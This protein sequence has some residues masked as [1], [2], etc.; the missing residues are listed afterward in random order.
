MEATEQARDGREVYRV[1][2]LCERRVGVGGL[3]APKT[4]VVSWQVECSR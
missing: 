3:L 4:L 2:T 1:A